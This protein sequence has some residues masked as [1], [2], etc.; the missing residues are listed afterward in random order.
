MAGQFSMLIPQA[1]G[2]IAL[3]LAVFGFL[4]YKTYDFLEMGYTWQGLTLLVAIFGVFA[5]FLKVWKRFFQRNTGRLVFALWVIAML[6]AYFGF[7]LNAPKKEKDLKTGVH[8][9]R[10]AP[11]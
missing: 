5:I 2:I 8:E 7:L 9:H 6:G 11:R 1:L 10:D 4:S 3:I